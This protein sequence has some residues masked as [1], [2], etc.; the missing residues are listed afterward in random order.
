MRSDT[1]ESA[2]VPHID[3]AATGSHD[4]LVVGAS[5]GERGECGG[6]IVI[7]A[8]CEDGDG[9]GREHVVQDEIVLLVSHREVVLKTLRETT[10]KHLFAHRLVIV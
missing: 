6:I 8:S 5:E 9:F 1:F 4:D 7:V 3:G 2:E 10:A